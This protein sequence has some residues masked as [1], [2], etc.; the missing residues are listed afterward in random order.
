MRPQQWSKNLFVLAPLLFSRNLFILQEAT[1][2]L[3]TFFL[4]CLISSAV[5]LLND[6]HDCEQD[7]LHPQKRYRPIAAGQLSTSITLKAMVTFLFLALAGGVLL[8]KFLALIL[9]GYW[10]I[11]LAYSF[12]LKR[13]VLLDVFALASGFLLRVIGGAIAL[14]VEI[15]YWLLLCTTFL[16]LFLSFSK[17]RHELV[18][19]GATAAD[20]R[21]VLGKY[22][23]PFLDMMTG[24][25]ATS[26]VISYTF[27]TIS[28]TTFSKF[29][30]R[31]LLLTIPFVLYGI[32]R[33][34][35]LVYQKDQVKDPT[36]LLLTD[37]PMVINFCLWTMSA[38]RSRVE[39]KTKGLLDK[40]KD[41]LN[42]ELL[43]AKAPSFHEI[44][45]DKK[46]AVE[47][48]ARQTARGQDHDPRWGV[49]RSGAPRHS[50]TTAR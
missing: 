36:Q 12:W 23:L 48:K 40:D 21:K 8:S 18:L 28:E 14:Q 34:L 43:Q 11:N 35:Y 27:Y 32:S 10:T 37:P 33:Y 6:I 9:F 17:R 38:G 50:S 4:F 39:R 3:E 44:L 31:G 29:H 45:A 13:Y 7:R 16:A 24:I 46:T 22:D 49:V 5:Y 30:T 26:T 1:R 2:S 20:H 19:L 42:A 47:P 15:S 41:S 25:T